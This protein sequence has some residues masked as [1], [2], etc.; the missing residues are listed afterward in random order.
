MKL[1]VTFFVKLL[2]YLYRKIFILEDILCFKFKD[3]Y[4]FVIIEN[5]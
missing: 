5:N 3:D 1:L 2:S 4:D